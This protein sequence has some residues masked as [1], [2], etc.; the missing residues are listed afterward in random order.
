MATS[1]SSSIATVASVPD[2]SSVRQRNLR[3]EGRRVTGRGSTAKLKEII[4]IGAV[5]LTGQIMLQRSLGISGG[6][7]HA[8]VVAGAAAGAYLCLRRMMV[9]PVWAA[10]LGAV[11]FLCHP[12]CVAKTHPSIALAEALPL[13][14]VPWMLL[15][16]RQCARRRRIHVALSCAAVLGIVAVLGAS[17]WAIAMMLPVLCLA[18]EFVLIERQIAWRRHLG[19]F[20]LVVIIA[21]LGGLALFAALSRWGPF[22]TNLDAA[23]AQTALTAPL[24]LIDR[25]GA[26]SFRL[27]KLPNELVA[28][29]GAHYLGFSLITLCLIAVWPSRHCDHS[30]RAAAWIVLAMVLIWMSL[31]KNL[32]IQLQSMMEFATVRRYVEPATLHLLG[33]MIVALL[34]VGLLLFLSTARLISG[35]RRWTLPAVMVASALLML[36]WRTAPPELLP[37]ITR[38]MAPERSL[39]ILQSLTAMLLVDAAAAG[40]HRTAHAQVSL[41]RRLLTAAILIALVATD[42]YPYAKK[43]WAQPEEQARQEVAKSQTTSP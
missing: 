7:A 33:V 20:V 35:P 38:W 21:A 31:G 25:D 19:W 23:K 22:S 14:L 6:F 32:H 24:A 30:R 40:M 27:V 39:P 15:L 2:A 28:G 37:A 13:L 18:T 42:V 11:L 5:S 3:A 26:L 9:L 36:W 10:C 1:P 41:H 43:T 34:A 17:T 4:L 29:G 8:A 12:L 16:C